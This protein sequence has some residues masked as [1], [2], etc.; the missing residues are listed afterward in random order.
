MNTWSETSTECQK[1][2]REQGEGICNEKWF[3]DK[4]GMYGCE[5][6]CGC[7]YGTSCFKCLDKNVRDCRRLFHK[8]GP[9]FCKDDF[10]IDRYKRY[11][12]NKTCGWCNK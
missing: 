11:G 4:S 7:C 12:C 3:T 5:K 8:F 2:F 6:T 10:F 1:L 9:R